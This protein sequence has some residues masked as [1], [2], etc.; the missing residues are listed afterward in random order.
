[1]QHHLADEVTVDLDDEHDHVGVRVGHPRVEAGLHQRLRR[2]Y[3]WTVAGPVLHLEV[4][5]HLPQLRQVVAFDAAQP[6]PVTA[7]HDRQE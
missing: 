7:Q 2:R 1:V 6:H 5:V 3:R 4:V